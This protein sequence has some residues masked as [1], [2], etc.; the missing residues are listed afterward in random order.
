MGYVFDTMDSWRSVLVRLCLA[1][2]VICGIWPLRRS[3]VRALARGVMYQQNWTGRMLAT[4]FANIDLDIESAHDI[5]PLVEFW[6]EEL[7]VFR[8]EQDDGVWFGTFETSEE[9]AEAIVEKYY[10]LVSDLTPD[11]RSIW[12]R[13]T[14]K[15]FDF[16]FNAGP[17]PHMYQFS[18]SHEAISKLSSIGGSIAVTIYAPTS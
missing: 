7:I 15:V 17:E 13:A 2:R 3:Q 18:V 1:I 4:S 12:D 14:K 9:T 6:G 11:L 8:L 10:R 5:T 16:G